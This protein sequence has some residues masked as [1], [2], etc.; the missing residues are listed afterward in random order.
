MKGQGKPK[1]KASAATVMAVAKALESQYKRGE[2]VPQLSNSVGNL[3]GGAS[4]VWREPLSKL[5]RIK[6]AR[7][8]AAKK[9]RCKQRKARK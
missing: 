2:D 7:G 9:A 3:G 5:Q 4:D 8:K 1:Q 6:R